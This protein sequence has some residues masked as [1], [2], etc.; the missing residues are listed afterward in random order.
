[1]TFTPDEARTVWACFDQP[2]LKAPHAFTVTA[3]AGWTVV[4]NS[5]D[6]DV[7][8]LGSARRWTFPDPP[9]LATYNTVINAGPWHEIRHTR[10]ATTSASSQL[11]RHPGHSPTAL[12]QRARSGRVLMH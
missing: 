12:Q 3:P 9:P 4:C 10:T 5:G 2:D 6:P 7:E 1:M 11:G 8:D